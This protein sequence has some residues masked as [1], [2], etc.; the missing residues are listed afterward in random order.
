MRILAHT[1][2]IPIIDQYDYIVRQGGRV[3]DAHWAHDWHWSPIGHRWAAEALLEYLK[4][5]PEISE[6]QMAKEMR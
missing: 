5:H 1:R 2:K 6:E 4:Q 3:E